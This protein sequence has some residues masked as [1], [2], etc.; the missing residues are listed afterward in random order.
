MHERI[1]VTGING[2]VGYHLAKELH[3]NGIDVIGIGRENNPPDKLSPFLEEYIKA[4]L[5]SE[6]PEIKKPI[7]SIIHLA[8]LAAVGP[9]FD[10]PQSYLQINSSMVTHMCES[11]LRSDDKPRIIAVSSGAIYDAKQEMPISEDGKI[12]FSSPY[13]VSKVLVEN[14]CAYYRNRGLDC[15]VLRPFNHIG[16]GQNEGFILPDLYTQLSTATD[17]V[18]RV[19]NLETQRDY[20]DVRDIVRAYGKIALAPT[21][22]HAVYNVCSGRSLSGN[23]ILSV[24]KEEMDKE[25]I[26]TE[27]DQS[28]IRPNDIPNITGN[29]SRLRNELGWEPTISINHTIKDF[30][31]EKENNGM[32]K[33]RLK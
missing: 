32:E 31:N 18:I 6:W 26:V 1:V 3:S 13:A 28:K 23:D 10:N 17:G 27:I 20:T 9:S 16:P 21:L 29:S 19:G 2:F 25:N 14:Q 8:G 22:Q 30:V 11:Y 24:L 33:D 15:V 7:K 4:D 12:G 5:S